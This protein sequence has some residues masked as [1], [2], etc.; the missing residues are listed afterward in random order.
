VPY[1]RRDRS[2]RL[3]SRL[4]RQEPLLFLPSISSIV[5]LFQTDYF[6]ENLVAPGIEPGTSGSVARYSRPL[7]HR[8]SLHVEIQSKESVS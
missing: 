3:Y 6:S 5:S 8:G 1:C 4:S 2:L 7:D